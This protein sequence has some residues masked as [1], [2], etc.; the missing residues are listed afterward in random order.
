M[1]IAS[2]LFCGT[3]VTDSKKVFKKKVQVQEPALVGKKKQLL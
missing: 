2:I 3:N 1:F